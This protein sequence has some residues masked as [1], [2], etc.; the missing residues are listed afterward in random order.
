MGYVREVRHAGGSSG[1]PP[2]A[3]QGHTSGEFTV[4]RLLSHLSGGS[5]QAV[6]KLATVDRSVLWAARSI[7]SHMSNWLA[8]CSACCYFEPFQNV[9]KTFFVICV[10]HVLK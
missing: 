2:A 9:Y 1:L 10:L 6:S 5:G 4:E 8:M 3:R 7:S